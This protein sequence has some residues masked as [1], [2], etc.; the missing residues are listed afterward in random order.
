MKFFILFLSTLISSAAF[1]SGPA[2][3]KC[4]FLDRNLSGVYTTHVQVRIYNGTRVVNDIPNHA[5]IARIQPGTFQYTERNDEPLNFKLVNQGMGQGA[6]CIIDFGGESFKAALFEMD[7]NRSFTFQLI[8]DPKQF[9][10]LER[11][12]SE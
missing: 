9:L 3:S 11:E 12:K 5:T 2:I 6:N 4:G 8:A 10:V 1:A 7:G